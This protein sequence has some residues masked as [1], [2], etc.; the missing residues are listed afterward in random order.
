MRKL[1]ATAILSA[2]VLTGTP[3]SS[4][5]SLSSI[6]NIP[7]IQIPNIPI[8]SVPIIPTPDIPAPGTSDQDKINSIGYWEDYLFNEM[9]TVRSQHGLAPYQWDG[10]L[11]ADG[12][13]WANEMSATNV[14]H[15][16]PKLGAQN[17][18]ENIWMTWDKNPDRSTQ[19]FMDSPGHR[20]NI[21]GPYNKAS[22]SLSYNSER[23]VWYIVQRF[24]W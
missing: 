7:T 1:I 17:Q 2:V 12:K 5:N 18:G 22:V 13:S 21:L 3:A 8:S 10:R 23:D 6:D 4:A 16:D 15:H 14:Y 9:N 24:A 20:D 19:A 11:H